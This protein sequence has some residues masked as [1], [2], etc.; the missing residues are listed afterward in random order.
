MMLSTK[1]VSVDISQEEATRPIKQIMEKYTKSRVVILTGATLDEVLYF[2]WKGQPVLALKESG[3]AVVITSY[4]AQDVVYYDT[5]R[6]R[7][8]TMSKKAAE[9][10]FSKGGKIFISFLY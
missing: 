10:E 2:V 6:G 3:E 5:A 9:D 1:G 4:N 8:V 7:N